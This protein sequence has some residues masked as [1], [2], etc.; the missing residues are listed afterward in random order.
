MV[1]MTCYRSTE[2]AQL[3]YAVREYTG[4]KD[5]PKGFGRHGLRPRSEPDRARLVSGQA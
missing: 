4:P 1:D 2:R 3:F 5:H